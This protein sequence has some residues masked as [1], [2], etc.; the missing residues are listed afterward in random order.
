MTEIS[1]LKTEITEQYTISNKSNGYS[2]GSNMRRSLRRSMRR[3]MR[4]SIRRS[5]QLHTTL[6][7]T[8]HTMLHTTLHVTLHAGHSWLNSIMLLYIIIL[9]KSYIVHDVNFLC[10]EVYVYRS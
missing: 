1:V 7:A 10:L 4:R 5:M 3:S 9:T 6:Y 8:L 2:Q